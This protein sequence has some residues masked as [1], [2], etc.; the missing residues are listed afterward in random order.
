MSDTTA[1]GRWS[2][3]GPAWDRVERILARA[4][5]VSERRSGKYF[6]A[7]DE[8]HSAAATAR[9]A[10]FIDAATQGDRGAFEKYLSAQGISY[11]EFLSGF[12][13]VT[14]KSPHVLP[15]WAEALIFFLESQADNGLSAAQTTKAAAGELYRSYTRAGGYLLSSCAR[16]NGVS[17]STQSKAQLAG[18]LAN[19]LLSATAAVFDFELQVDTLTRSTGLIPSSV[20]TVIDLTL[21]GW[22]RRLEL[23]PGLAY[24]VGVT[25]AN[26]ALA[27]SEL[28]DRI[29]ADW[30][31]LCRE[32][33]NG[34]GSPELTGFV[35]DAGDTHNGGRS[36]A[37]LTFGKSYKVA[38][39]AKDLRCAAAFIEFMRFLNN[40]RP[41]LQFP[42]RKII[43]RCGYAWEQYI[44][45]LPCRTVQ[46]IERFFLRMGMIL[47]LIQFV[48]ARDFW[49][50]NLIASGDNPVFADLE[51][52]V[53]PRF[54][55]MSN[56][57]G[58]ERLVDQ[59]L[60][61]SVARTGAVTAQ[62][63]IE[64]GVRAEDFGALAPVRRRLT[65][66]RIS[67]SA[68]F[69]IWPG[70]EIRNRYLTWTPAAHAPTLNGRPANS[71]D[72]VEFL[73]EG[74]RR[75]EECLRQ[76]IGALRNVDG[77]LRSFQDVQVRFIWRDTWS[78]YAILQESLGLLSLQSGTSREISI[79]RM[80]RPYLLE[81]PTHPDILRIVVS[82][83]E[84][85]RDLD[86]P[87]FTAAANS[88]SIFTP[89]GKEI[90][91]IFEGSAYER[92]MGRTAATPI[93]LDEHLDLLRSCIAVLQVTDSCW[94]AVTRTAASTS[95]GF[96]RSATLTNR[97]IEIADFIIE[98]AKRS[99]TDLAWAG[100]QYDPYH[101]SLSLS[102][103]E[104]E[105]LNGTS[106][107]AI[108]FAELF[109]ATGLDHFRR[110]ALAALDATI[111]AVRS[112]RSGSWSTV[113]VRARQACGAFLGAGAQIYALHRC[114]LRLHEKSLFDLANE[115]VTALPVR[116]LCNT[117]PVD[118]INGISGLLIVLCGYQP[119][120]F[121]PSRDA[122]GELTAHLLKS[123]P[124]G[125]PPPPYPLGATYMDGLPG[126]TA[127]VMM[128]LRRAYD[129]G[130]VPDDVPCLGI[131]A[132]CA[133]SPCAGDLLASLSDPP[134]ADLTL[135]ERRI[136]R[137]LDREPGTMSSTEL[138]DATEVAITA[139]QL[140]R[141]ERFYNS[142]DSLARY[143]IDR[144]EDT[145]SWFPDHR[146]ADRHNLSIVRGVAAVAHVLL[147]LD[148]PLRCCSVR[149]LRVPTES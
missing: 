134:A 30:E 106:G 128:A 115:L 102:V 14:V 50:D 39:K 76:N 135:A 66:L 53:Q 20:G 139:Y 4:A 17:L 148:D 27:T 64:A 42:T 117:C 71:L 41:P 13:D 33:W 120:Q 136:E 113:T 92:L 147:E 126:T 32:L 91:G 100:L 123:F 25:C 26:W 78:Y 3:S 101:D 111:R 90:K 121:A 2:R 19:R 79:A 112:M 51:A 119:G 88:R 118:V 114:A 31:L 140:T 23:L 61:E 89:D 81:P 5:P 83:I 34:A 149:L 68:M 18:Q 62:I 97:A 29:G 38:Y 1:T 129:A 104:P 45:Q 12:A 48:E 122:L 105:L 95:D 93:D 85:I 80:L 9:A 110:A 22:L 7:V 59:L 10:E 72:Y 55:Q 143:M 56:A 87:L 131:P 99:G 8:Q 21:D 146:A 109:T 132:L 49:L 74:Y 75:M 127:G 82:E 16:T 44:E 60:D 138:L 125:P 15:D 133:A 36:V 144:H 116:Q 6:I 57:S 47:R 86:V 145:G 69:S 37:L 94:K 35:G 108:L 130:L 46:Q 142:A 65:P 141:N 137:W 63:P 103:L 58:A 70:A 73:L 40:A 28:F 98:N 54:P 96:H 124:G 43:C 11:E 107:L 52:I 24:V 67:A 84:A 77:P